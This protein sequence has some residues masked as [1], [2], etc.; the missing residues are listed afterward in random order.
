MNK[1]LTKIQEWFNVNKLSLNV[2]KTKY[3]FF[4]R[5]AWSERIPLKS[6]QTKTCFKN[7]ENTSCIDLFITNSEIAFKTQSHCH[8]AYLTVIK[9]W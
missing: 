8:V 1:E 2:S 3:S 5:L 7:P 4:H 9:W 6:C